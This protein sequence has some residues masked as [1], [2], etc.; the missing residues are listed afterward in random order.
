MWLIFSHQFDFDVVWGRPRSTWGAKSLRKPH[1]L[2]ILMHTAPCLKTDTLTKRSA[3]DFSRTRPSFGVAYPST[4]LLGFAAC[5]S[6]LAITFT[7]SL[8][9][10]NTCKTKPGRHSDGPCPLCRQ[11]RTL[12]SALFR[13]EITW[14]FMRYVT[15]LTQPCGTWW[16]AAITRRTNSS[17]TSRVP[18][19]GTTTMDA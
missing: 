12:D 15:T 4:Q 16:G 9:W 11:W 13:K 6:G 10:T 3:Q 8:R 1:V 2:E 17:A 14:F 19:W 5:S 7:W 18:P